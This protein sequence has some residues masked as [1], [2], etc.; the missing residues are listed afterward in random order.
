MLLLIPFIVYHAVPPVIHPVDWAALDAPTRHVRA[1]NANARDALSQGYRRSSTFASIVDRL[2]ISDVIVY[3]SVVPHLSAPIRARSEMVATSLDTRY[4]RVE[5]AAAAQP[6]ET[7][8][9]VA[10]E[11]RH[12]LEIADARGVVDQATLERLYRRI[13]TASGPNMFE[14]ETAID[15]EWQVRKELCSRG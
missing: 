3:V 5:V 7:I 12:A 8:A 11:L 1:E 4:V 9:L 2:D 10:H 14:T 6:V 15:T 13:G